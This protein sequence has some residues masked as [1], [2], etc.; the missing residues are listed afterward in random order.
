[1]SGAVHIYQRGDYRYTLRANGTVY[2]DMIEA[3][4]AAGMLDCAAELS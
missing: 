3:M 1:M 2:Y 4:R